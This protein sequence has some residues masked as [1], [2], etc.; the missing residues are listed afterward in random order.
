MTLPQHVVQSGLICVLIPRLR[1]RHFIIL[2]IVLTIIP[3]VGRLFQ[4]NPD[5]WTQFYEWAHTTWYCFLFPFWN[6][7]IAED[8]LVHQPG[9]GWYWWAYYLEVSLWIVESILILT[10]YKRAR[11]KQNVI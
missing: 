4:Q 6:L 1:R 8:Y 3:D 9:G 7:H 10:W 11:S 5:D 2:A